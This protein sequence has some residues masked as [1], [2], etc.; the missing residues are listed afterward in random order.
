MEE[1][2]GLRRL[3]EPQIGSGRENPDRHDAVDRPAQSAG[4]ARTGD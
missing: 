3:D 2:A 4:I 1:R